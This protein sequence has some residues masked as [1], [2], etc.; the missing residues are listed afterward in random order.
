MHQPLAEPLPPEILPYHHIQND[1][2]GDTIANLQEAIETY[3]GLAIRMLYLRAHYRS[4]L[5]FSD[6][7]VRDAQTAL[8]RIDRTL[9][10][11]PRQEGV[12]ADPDVIGR[13]R[14]A[15]DD[16]FGT[17]EALGV[18]FDAIRDANRALDE[19]AD[20]A[21]LMAAVHEIVDVLGLRG[22]GAGLDDLADA[23][24]S[25]AGELGVDTGGSTEELLDRLVAQRAEARAA[26]DF[27]TSD[28]IRDRLG[29]LGVTV[30]DGADG[31]RWIRR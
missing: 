13:F 15:M 27:D 8:Q 30:E 2:I 5:E 7:L 6:E 16:D 20:A 18:L 23:V 25:L 26:R 3:G 29:E 21:T 12:E 11:A 31:S 28:R 4:P 19:G 14:E 10:R 9:E 17:P 24:G 22:E 1:G